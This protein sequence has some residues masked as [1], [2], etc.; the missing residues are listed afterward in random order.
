M[1]NNE[2]IGVL[3]LECPQRHSA[4]RVLKE[5]AHHQVQYDPGPAVGPRQFWPQEDEQ[6]RFKTHCRHCDKPVWG[7]SA[8][9]Q[10][11]LIELLAD[12]SATHATVTLQY[13]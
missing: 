6:G 8:T 11:K 5:A 4:G 12:D 10:G 1:G 9:L 2:G 7:P 13:L 3:Q